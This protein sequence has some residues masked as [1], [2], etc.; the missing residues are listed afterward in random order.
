MVETVDSDFNVKQYPFR[1]PANAP[2]PTPEPDEMSVEAVIVGAGWAGISA[3]DPG[4]T[5]STG[6]TLTTF[7]AIA[8][9]PYDDNER[10]YLMPDYIRNLDDE[11]EFLVHLGDLQAEVDRCREYAY[12]EAADILGESRVTTFVLPGDN[13]INDCDDVPHGESMW[14]E[15]LHKFD[16]RWDHSFDMRRWGSLDESF[17]FVHRRVLYFALNIVGGQPYNTTEKEE[18]HREHLTQIRATLSELED[19]D[20]DVM[21]LFGH[22]EPSRHHRDFFRGSD[23]FYSIV[24]E[25]GKPT[26]HLH[27][28]W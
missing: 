27:G 21:V 18:R 3:V 25:V 9:C 28:D 12:R 22:A 8:D 26:L 13:D 2:S 24:A 23:G 16:E 10:Q 11:A 4:L 15:Y 1:V 19:D 6:D 5:D 20:F 17:T 7:Y 14:L